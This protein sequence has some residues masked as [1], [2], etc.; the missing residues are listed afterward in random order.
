M[1]LIIGLILISVFLGFVFSPKGTDN[2]TAIRN[3][4]LFLSGSLFILFLIGVIMNASL[5]SNSKKTKEAI[6]QEKIKKQIAKRRSNL[7]KQ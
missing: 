1:D 7:K 2:Q 6:I 5:A 4:C 3:G